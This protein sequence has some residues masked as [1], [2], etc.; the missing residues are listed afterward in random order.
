VVY[1]TEL[2]LLWLYNHSSVSSTIVKFNRQINEYG[3]EK[4]SIAFAAKKVL[5]ISAGYATI[6]LNAE[7]MR[8]PQ[9]LMLF[10]PKN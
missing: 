8:P 1:W 6:C 9:A 5:I 2:L 3:I 7:T 4:Y 10:S